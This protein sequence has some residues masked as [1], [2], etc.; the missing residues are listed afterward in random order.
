MTIEGVWQDGMMVEYILG[1]GKTSIKDIL[2]G[3]VLDI[4][5]MIKGDKWQKKS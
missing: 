4:N 2:Q 1:W 5:F 3:F